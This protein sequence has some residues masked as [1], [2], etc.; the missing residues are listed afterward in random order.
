VNH[1]KLF[2]SF[3]TSGPSSFWPRRKIY[4]GVKVLKVLDSEN[5]SDKEKIKDY[6]KLAFQKN[7]WFKSSFDS[8]NNL[9]SGELPIWD[10]EFAEVLMP[11]GKREI[12]AFE[13]FDNTDSDDKDQGII[14][15][16]SLD[17]RWSF[18]VPATSSGEVE[19]DEL[20]FNRLTSRSGLR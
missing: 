14:S 19:W 15:A 4:R 5:P 10:V 7:G 18:W 9:I 8:N 20:D 16:E 1:L 3:S 12:L 6:M 17:G 2:E 11:T 13:D